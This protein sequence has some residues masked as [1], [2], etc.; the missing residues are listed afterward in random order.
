MFALLLLCL[1][2]LKDPHNLQQKCTVYTVCFFFLYNFSVKHF[3]CNKCFELV[4]NFL[5]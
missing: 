5:C 2:V 3:Q 1:N 4:Y